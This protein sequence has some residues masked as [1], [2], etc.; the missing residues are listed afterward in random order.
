MDKTSKFGENFCTHKP[1]SGVENIRFLNG[2]HSPADRAI[3][4]FKSGLIGERLVALAEK[5][6]LFAVRSR[7]LRL[8]LQNHKLFWHALTGFSKQSV[9]S[10]A[11]GSAWI[12]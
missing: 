2:H 7:P 5:K 1:L 10:A 4:L 6:N 9:T 3:D 11:S 12:K 8:C